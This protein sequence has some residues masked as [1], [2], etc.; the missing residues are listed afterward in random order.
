MFYE[1]DTVRTGQNVNKETRDILVSNG[2]KPGQEGTVEEIITYV[3]VDFNGKKLTIREDFLDLKE[4]PR[5][6]PM[7]DATIKNFI[8]MFGMKK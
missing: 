3:V 5:Q 8:D 7:D 6:D 1:G 4:Y 2:I